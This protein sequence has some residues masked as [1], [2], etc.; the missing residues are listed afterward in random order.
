METHGLGGAGKDPAVLIPISFS[1]RDLDNSPSHPSQVEGA[2]TVKKEVLPYTELISFPV[3]QSLTKK[4]QDSTAICLSS[5]SLSQI[6]LSLQVESV[7]GF[8]YWSERA[9]AFSSL[10]EPI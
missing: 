1:D 2:L 9:Q 8:L 6:L 3:C 4:H 7:L 10:E 5:A